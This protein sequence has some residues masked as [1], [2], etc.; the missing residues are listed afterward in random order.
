M[1]NLHQAFDGIT[2]RLGLH[3]EP[4]CFALF[5]S[6]QK[7]SLLQGVLHSVMDHVMRNDPLLR[8]IHS[9]DPATRPDYIQGVKLAAAFGEHEL[10]E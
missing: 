8:T 3:V 9:L 7:P 1:K 2:L 10:H 5:D 6:A 4:C